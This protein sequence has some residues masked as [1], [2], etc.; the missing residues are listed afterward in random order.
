MPESD[1]PHQNGLPGSHDIGQRLENLMTSVIDSQAAKRVRE[2]GDVAVLPLI[3]AL[4]SS[5]WRSH[6][7]ARSAVGL[8]PVL[9]RSA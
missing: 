4:T 3:D 6:T 1:Q 7:R 5:D 2:L 9:A 8:I